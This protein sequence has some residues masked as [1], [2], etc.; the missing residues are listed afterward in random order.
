MC[1]YFYTRMS[2]K[3]LCAYETPSVAEL[4][5]FLLADRHPTGHVNQVW[6]NVYIGNEY[7]PGS[8][9]TIH[10]ANSWSN[11]PSTQLNTCMFS[12]T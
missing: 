5:D 4:Q 11:R 1:V 3:E 8:R 9:P 2:L 7:V 12:V 6:F 10:K